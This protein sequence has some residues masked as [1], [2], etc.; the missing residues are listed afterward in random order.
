[1]WSLSAVLLVVCQ[2]ATEETWGAVAM[3]RAE[4]NKSNSSLCLEP[5]T[6]GPSYMIGSVWYPR[7]MCARA[8]CNERGDQLYVS[9]AT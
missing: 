4:Y 7:N 5:G 8:M 9:Y 1:M 6:T 3:G 2:L